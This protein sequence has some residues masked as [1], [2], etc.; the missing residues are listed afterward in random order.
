MRHNLI[1]LRKE[2]RSLCLKKSQAPTIMPSRV[3][4][5]K[6]CRSNGAMCFLCVA[7]AAHFLFSVVALPEA[8]NQKRLKIQYSTLLPKS[9]FFAELFYKNRNSTNFD[10]IFVFCRQMW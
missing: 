9:L 8:K 1:F 5:E 10:K 7:S 2:M 3:F 4:V 6:L